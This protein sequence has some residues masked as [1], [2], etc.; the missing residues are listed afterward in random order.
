MTKHRAPLPRRAIEE[1]DDELT[2]F[3]AVRLQPE[4]EAE[5]EQLGK[6]SHGVKMTLR[7]R[8]G[9]PLLS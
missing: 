5:L 6:A 2:M 3:S 7:S 8:D 9:R 1:S 4:A